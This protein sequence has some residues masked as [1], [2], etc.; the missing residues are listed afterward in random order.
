VRQAADV[1]RRR[2][3]QLT[4]SRRSNGFFISGDLGTIHA[5]GY[6]HMLGRAKDLII[7]DGFN[8]YPNGVEIGIDA[9]PGVIECAVVGLLGFRA[10]QPPHWHCASHLYIAVRSTPIVRAAVLGL[11]PSCTR[12]ARFQGRMIQ[13]TRARPIRQEKCALIHED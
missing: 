11:S 7:T 12:R 1:A 4:P 13:E 10:H 6:V 3:A 5:D 2:A 9:L 8:V